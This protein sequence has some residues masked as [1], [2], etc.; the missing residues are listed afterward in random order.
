VSIF[1]RPNEAGF[2]QVT[3]QRF[4]MAAWFGR[5]WSF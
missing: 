1:F 5:Q 2:P 3:L 4:A